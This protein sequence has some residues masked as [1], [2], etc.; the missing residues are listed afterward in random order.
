MYLVS[1]ILKVTAKY[2]NI[3]LKDLVS[4]RR[5]RYNLKPRNMVIF[6]GVRLGISLTSIGLAFSRD[7]NTMY[8]A[9]R[10]ML[11]DLEVSPTLREELQEILQMLTPPPCLPGEASL[12][13]KL[14]L[15]DYNLIT[16]KKAL[17]ELSETLDK[18]S[19]ASIQVFTKGQL[20]AI[21][22][23]EES[24]EK[25]KYNILSQIEA[26]WVH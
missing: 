8:A 2:Y 13:A 12:R 4:K 21:R 14:D 25:Q 7:Y 15:I 19:D 6:I 26:L 16:L 5:L 20:S 18:T 23:L 17:Q 3:P 9:Q 24:L 11:R 22:I 1:D 10:S